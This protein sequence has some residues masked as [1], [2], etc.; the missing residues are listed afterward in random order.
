MIPKVEACLETLDKGVRKIHIIDGRQRHSL[1]LEIYTS[2]GVG[3]EIVKECRLA[4][5]RGPACHVGSGRPNRAKV[6]RFGRRP[7]RICTWHRLSV[8][9]AAV[10]PTFRRLQSMAEPPTA[11]SAETLE[12]FKRYVVPNYSRY[13]VCLVRGEGSYVWDSDGQ[14]Y[15]DFFP[16][17]G[18]N[19]L[20]HCPEPVVKAV[21]EQVA[22]LIHVPNTWYTEAQGR[23]PRP[24]RS[25]ASAG[26][27]SSAIREP[28]PTRRPSSWPGCTRP[29]SATRSS[30][31][32]AAF[33]AARWAR[34]RP[35]PSPSI[36]KGWAR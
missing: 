32:K 16:G 14:R 21:Q 5:E 29:R 28:R 11:R 8:R 2:K 10:L 30:P 17:W 4:I 25:A 23:G 6:C 7:G 22:T 20:G 13:P 9:I 24:C 27:H 33:T 18:C 12:L 19:L 26:R 36:T 1:L 35:R 3:T 31:S 34:R 15:L